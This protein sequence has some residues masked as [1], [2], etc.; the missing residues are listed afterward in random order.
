MNPPV[1][2]LRK[3]IS[4]L[5]VCP[6]LYVQGEGKLMKPKSSTW[7]AMFLVLGVLVVTQN[8]R[9]Q[10]PKP[11]KSVTM[12]YGNTRWFPTFWGPYTSP[13]VPE[14][15]MSNSERLHA[16]IRDGKL[17]LSVEDA[18]ALA[19]ENNLDIAVARYNV[20]FAQTDLIR[21]LSGG[22]A[23]GVQGAVIS[24]ALFGGALGGGVG[25]SEERR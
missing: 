11:A 24:S 14:P 5:A 8:V 19:L 1:Q 16:L 17:H 23:R 21:T 25:R 12:Q 4:V 13:Y 6:N 15:R 2:V 9:A 10:D 3:Y 18:I 7:L 22:A 20:A